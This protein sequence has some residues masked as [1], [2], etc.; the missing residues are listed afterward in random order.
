MERRE[1]YTI[2]FVFQL[3]MIELVNV[4]KKYGASLAVDNIS[5]L[6]RESETLV[7]LGTSACGKTTTLRMVNRLIE[8]T[9]G[10]IYFNGEDITKQ[11]AEQVRRK[12]GYV[13][14]HTGLFPH[15]TVEENISTVPNL[16][17]WPKNKTKARVQE[18]LA[19]L[20]LDPAHHLLAY[21]TQ[22]SGGQ[23][24][25]VGL[26]RALAANP[27]VLLMDEPFGAL[28]PI[29]KNEIRKEF[30][31][32]DELK[33]KTIILVTHDV[34][35]AFELADRICLM[36]KGH[37]VQI[38]TPAELL[39]RPANDFARSFLQ[40]QHL[41]LELQTITLNDVWNKLPSPIKTFAEHPIPANESLWYALQKLA[42]V[43]ISSGNFFVEKNGIKK[44]IH[45]DDLM[46]AYHQYKT[47]AIA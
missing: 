32:L 27:P 3:P 11:P 36:D 15:F 37:I 35:E 43:P 9:S 6:V 46:A 40:E 45:T 31:M 24:Q 33:S 42:A 34:Q 7:L 25:R 14:Q 26:A 30:K 39:F 22:L 10:T 16:L 41:L 17:S 19:K 4:T 21:P 29:T 38:G 23:Q 20:K 47:A 44:I 2:T 12:M 28:D 13:L 8:P 1:D 5:F 18:L